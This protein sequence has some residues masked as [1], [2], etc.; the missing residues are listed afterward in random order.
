VNIS[1]PTFSFCVGMLLL[2]AFWQPSQADLP[3]IEPSINQSSYTVQ[4]D[5]VLVV[6]VIGFTD[7]SV[8]QVIVM[9][10][11]TI[12]VP[13]LGT[14]DVA[15]ETPLQ[16]QDDLAKRWS[17]YVINPSVTVALLQKH[18]QY[19][20]F[21]GYVLHPGPEDYRPNYHVLEA[22]AESGGAL[23][24]GDLSK[25]TVTDINGNKQ[26]IDLSHPEKKAGTNADVLLNVGDVVYVP[27][28]RDEFS[29]VG[30]VARPGSYPYI[31][32]ETV[33]DLLTTAG[34]TL[35]D[36]DLNDARLWHN[37]VDSPINLDALLRH[38]DLSQNIK[39]SAGDRLT[40]PEGYRTYVYG[41]VNHPGY[42][43]FTPGDHILDA[44]NAAGGP[45]PSYGGSTGAPDLAKVHLIRVDK[46]KNTVVVYSVD[47]Q[48]FLNKGVV[49]DNSV[50]EPGDVLFI[51]S[52]SHHFAISDLSSV[53]SPLQSIAY[54]NSLPH[55]F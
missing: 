45:L 14:V 2:I 34:N 1:Q 17:K 51:P 30:Q 21:S 7:L 19:V 18:K 36:A 20:T 22:L 8:P 49:A 47:L 42:Y 33:L 28:V 25:A 3:S 37:G 6:T 27:Q 24:T 5:D 39:L 54:A 12:N 9:Q 44:L 11:G 55:A 46:A 16:I 31:E 50:L 29:V 38:G 32:D 13:L 43:T 53:L 26:T 15:G 48:K 35:P 41:A 40:V 4:A 52:R 10:D 23:P